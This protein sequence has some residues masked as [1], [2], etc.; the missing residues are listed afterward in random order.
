MVPH[1]SDGRVMFAIPWHGHT[2]VG[3]TDTPIAQSTLE[4]V[5]LEQE[6]EFILQTASL[7]LDKK[8]VRGDVLSVF[9]GIRPLVR[10]GESG[11]TAALSRDHTIRIE[12][13][14]MITI[15]GGKWTTYRHMAEDCVNQAAT[16]ARLP[17]R[18][19]VTG[20]LNIH[21]FH[22]ASQKFG[23]LWVYGSDA[24]MVQ[25]LEAQPTGMGRAV[26]RR[27]ALHRRGSGLG[28]ASRTGADRGGC[29]G[30]PHAG[31]IPERPGRASHGAA[32]G[33]SHGAVNWDA[34][35]R[36]SRGKSRH[37]VKWRKV[38]LVNSPHET[39]AGKLHLR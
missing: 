20:H 19:C 36:G 21:G 24:R 29:A 11:N 31:V 8:P 10:S 25:E 22:P 37:L 5:A 13:S 14:G 35:A 23:H 27:A 26:G 30:A 28:G 18:P 9:A 6:V 12:N 39:L 32:G 4:P 1:T 7:Y 3:T 15:C 38:T 17:E 16:L 2:V 34:I 33:G